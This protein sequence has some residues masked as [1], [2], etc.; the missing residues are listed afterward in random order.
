M[1]DDSQHVVQGLVKPKQKI[2]SMTEFKRSEEVISISGR[3]G[4]G[5]N[6]RQVEFD[7][8]SADPFLVKSVR[9]AG[10]I[11]RTG[12][13][14]L[15]D[16]V[17]NGS[18]ATLVEQIYA[19]YQG[20]RIVNINANGGHIADL[21]FKT[22]AS[23]EQYEM[24]TQ[25]LLRGKTLANGVANSFSIPLSLF[26]L[27]IPYFMPTSGGARM[28]IRITL[29]GVRNLLVGTGTATSGVDYS[30]NDLRL[31]CDFYRLTS[32]AS[33]VLTSAVSSA[34]GLSYPMH[35]WVQDIQ[36]L[37]GTNQNLLVPMTYRNV[38][39]VFHLPVVQGTLVTD[40]NIINAQTVGSYKYN[41]ASNED[42]AK[43][44]RVQF[45]GSEYFNQ[46]SQVGESNGADHFVGLMKAARRDL[47][48]KSYGH[49]M[50][51]GWNT[52]NYQI[53]GASLLKGDDNDP[54][55][56]DSGYNGYVSNGQLKVELQT[57]D[58]GI[59]GYQLLTVGQI[60]RVLSIERGSVKVQE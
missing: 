30:L 5:P 37:S 60:T 32:D 17:L 29:A 52:A 58:L 23:Y 44:Y 54:H 2:N 16:V 26:G 24:E 51:V 59:N 55:V 40:G 47:F 38:T 28:K 4:F 48:S 6:K 34:T 18:A 53:L 19:D 3:D 13:A 1:S 45:T 12:G 25:T 35:S 15:T 20:E 57:P 10:T 46:N 22:M 49:G 8:Q 33:Q 31:V 39:N 43:N 41:A 9:L 21:A 42:Y 7:I 50:S 11:T 14:G 27:D 56:V 36:P